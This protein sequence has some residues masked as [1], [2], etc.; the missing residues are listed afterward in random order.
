MPPAQTEGFSAQGPGELVALDTVERVADG[1]R[2][3]LITFV[4][5]HSRFDSLAHVPG[6]P[7]DERSLAAASTAPYKRSSSTT[8][9]TSSYRPA[10]FNDKLMYWLL[11]YNGE[12]PHWALQLQSPL[13]FIACHYPDECN[14]CWPDTS[15]CLAGVTELR[16]TA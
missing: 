6:D 13:Q 3:Y 1:V 7:E 12:R 2:R 4:D 11:W 14:M 15:A 5:V 10:A 9:R 16:F 8:M